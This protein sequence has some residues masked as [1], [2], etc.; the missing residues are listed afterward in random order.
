MTEKMSSDCL[1]SVNIISN[2]GNC[3]DG[4][5]KKNLKIKRDKDVYS[6]LSREMDFLPPFRAR[7]DFISKICFLKLPQISLIIGA[8][9]LQ[10]KTPISFSRFSMHPLPT[11]RSTL[12]L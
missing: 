11:S 10:K 7:A 9:P 5:L 1:H 8:I 6:K 12:I 4:L 2:V 3:G